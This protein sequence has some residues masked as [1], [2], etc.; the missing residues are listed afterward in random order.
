MA[1]HGHTPGINR[2]VGLHIIQCPAQAPGP[3]RHATPFVRLGLG[4][5]LDDT[6]FTTGLPGTVLSM[7]GAVLSM[8]DAVLSMADAVLSMA[9]AG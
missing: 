5:A 2:L 3:G 1:H 7:A 6:R 4:R 8:A 9:D